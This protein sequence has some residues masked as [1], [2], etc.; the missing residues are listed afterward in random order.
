M[1]V[2]DQLTPAE[3]AQALGVTQATVR[4]R[5]HRARRALAAPGSTTARQ[6]E[7]AR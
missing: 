1:V 5:L 6:M 3:V 7:A 4:V 2:L